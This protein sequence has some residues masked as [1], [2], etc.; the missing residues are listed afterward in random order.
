MRGCASGP[1]NGARLGMGSS[2]P[3][4]ERA[5]A[6]GQEEVGLSSLEECLAQ[7]L[8]YSRYL[9]ELCQFSMVI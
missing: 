5:T 8:A 6:I 9:I 1:E 3:S 7:W 4:L 2:F